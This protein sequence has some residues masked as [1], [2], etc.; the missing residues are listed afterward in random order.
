MPLRLSFSPFRPVLSDKEDRT[1]VPEPDA[2]ETQ[3]AEDVFHSH[4]DRRAGEAVPQTEIPR[5]G[6]KGHPGEKSQDDRRAGQDL[7][8][9]QADKV[10]VS[11]SVNLLSAVL[12]FLSLPEVECENQTLRTTVLAPNFDNPNKK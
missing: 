7:V 10:A 6:R 5:L 2:A 4:P 1:S 3:E 12:S 11:L 8:P 9:E